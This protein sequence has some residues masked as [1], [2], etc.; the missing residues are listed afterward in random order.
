MP[1]FLWM[2]V[3]DPAYT[4]AAYPAGTEP[5]TVEEY[6]AELSEHMK[7]HEE[8]VDPDKSKIEEAEAARVKA[9]Q[10]VDRRKRMMKLQGE[11]EVGFH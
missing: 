7:W 3:A 9:E 6:K 5:M 8:L 4:Y 2:T 11:V 10:G 1:K